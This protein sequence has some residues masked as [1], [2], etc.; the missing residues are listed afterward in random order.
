[1]TDDLSDAT[2]EALVT[3]SK[4][5]LS[6]AKDAVVTA[7]NKIMT[8][9]IPAS[10][11]ENSKNQ[12][13]DELSF[14]ILPEKLKLATIELGRYAIIQN[15]F[16]DSEATE[17][18]RQQAMESVEPVLIKQ[19]QIIVE[20]GQLVSQEIFRQWNYLVLRIQIPS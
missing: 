20:E 15:E 14:T 6:L 12:V 19:G 18:L 2:L 13:E 8:N 10:E 11:V 7:V 3:S 1:M 9:R 16:Y 17:E 5:D 4:T